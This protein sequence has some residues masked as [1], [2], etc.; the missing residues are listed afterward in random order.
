MLGVEV[1]KKAADMIKEFLKSQETV[2]AVRIIT[3]IG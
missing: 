1:T 3:Q 2:S